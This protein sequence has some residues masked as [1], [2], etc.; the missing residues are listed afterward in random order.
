[1][2]R[3]R[4]LIGEPGA[5]FSECLR[6]QPALLPVARD[7]PHRPVLPQPRRAHQRAADRWLA[8]ACAAPPTGCRPGSRQAGYRTVH[9][10]K[11]LNHYGRDDPHEVPPGWDEWYATVDPTTYRY[12]GYTVNENGTLRT[13][14]RDQRPA[15]LLDRLHRPALGR[16][17]SSGSPRRAA[18]LP[19]GRLPRPAHRRAARARRPGLSGRRRSR[20]AT[21]AS[22]QRAAAPPGGA[23]TR[24]TSRTSR[25]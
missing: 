4:R 16:R 1:M 24:P 11:F 19:V 2:P 22:S 20:R 5:R 12:Y 15:L 25:R 21:A 9:V 23:S 13:Y 8:A 10:G 18:V 7:L 6:Q 14:G 3:T 17:S